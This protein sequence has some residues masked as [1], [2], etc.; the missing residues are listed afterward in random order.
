[1]IENLERY[2]EAGLAA[3]AALLAWCWRIARLDADRQGRIERLEQWRHK[4]SEF[5]GRQ[6][7]RLDA[8]ER[9][10]ERMDAKIDNIDSNIADVKQS[11]RDLT[12]SVRRSGGNCWYDPHNE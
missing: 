9:H 1:M 3:V 11:L 12:A 2:I 4:H 7:D 8:V 6:A 5:A 10:E